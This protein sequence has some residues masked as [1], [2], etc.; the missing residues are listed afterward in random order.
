MPKRIVTFRM[1]SES[2]LFRSIFQKKK[3]KFVKKILSFLYIFFNF[4]KS[5]FLELKGQIRNC[6]PLRVLYITK[7]KSKNVFGTFYPLK[8]KGP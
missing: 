6:F 3:M 5:F 8:N 4:Q 7:L 1:K 2:E